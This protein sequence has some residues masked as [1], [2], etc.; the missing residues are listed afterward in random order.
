MIHEII[1]RIAGGYNYR[2]AGVSLRRWE[3]E[4][5]DIGKHGCQLGNVDQLL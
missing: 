1:E 5:G 2:E 4:P 3:G